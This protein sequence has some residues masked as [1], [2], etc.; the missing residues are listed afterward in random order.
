MLQ[1]GYI[2]GLIIVI[3]LV[4]ISL[5]LQTKHKEKNV[6]S[7][8]FKSNKVS[9]EL[10]NNNELEQ[11]K[12]KLFFLI[13]LLALLYASTSTYNCFDLNNKYNAL[14]ERF[15]IILFVFLWSKV[16]LK[17]QIFHHHYFSL[18]ICFIGFILSSIPIFK[19]FTKN[20]ILHNLFT[21]IYSFIYSFFLVLINYT[22]CYHYISPYLC[23]L[24]IGLFSYIIIYFS[25]SIYSLIKLNN[26][27]YIADAFDFSVVKDK[28]LFYL[29]C[30]SGLIIFS[31]AQL[32]FTF[33]IY[34]FSPNLYVVTQIL[35]E[36]LSTLLNDIVYG[37]D[38]I[39]NIIFK[40]LIFFVFC[41]ATLIIN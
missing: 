37:G 10:I 33:I 15:F 25:F 6:L 27:S 19:V 32:L 24:Y 30:L 12:G 26:F 2:F 13:I 20:D 31:I 39:S 3:I 29:C 9:T 28:K 41:F 16:I 40:Y 18:L 21:L 8:K 14:N 22:T 34:F 4:L 38:N 36:I 5:C 23:L 1:L 17:I 7:I 11:K 35:R